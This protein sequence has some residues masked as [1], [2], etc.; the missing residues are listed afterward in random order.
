MDRK[1][2][3]MMTKYRLELIGARWIGVNGE[4]VSSLATAS[5]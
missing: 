3:V 1:A 2:D 4:K 5:R